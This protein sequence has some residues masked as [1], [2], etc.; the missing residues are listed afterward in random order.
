MKR[1]WSDQR[2][3]VTGASGFLGS[4]LL[5]VLERRK[6]ECIIAPRSSEYDLRDPDAI[7]RLLCR[8][9]PNLIIHLAAVCGGIGANQASPGQFFYDNAVMGI[10]LM[11]AARQH[12]VQ[13]F[14]QVGTVCA[15]PKFTPTPFK[16]DD[17]WDGYPEETNAPYGLAKKMLLVQAQAYR[18]QYGFNAIYLLPANLYGPRDH[19]DLEKSHVIPAL[20]RKILEAKEQNLPT[21]EAWGTGKPTR[22]FL[23]ARDAAEGILLAAERYDQ[24]EPVNLG[25]GQEISIRELVTLTAKLVGYKGKIIWN[26]SKPD[27]Q[28][29]RRLD[30]QRASRTFG[31]KSKVSLKIGLQKTIEWYLSTRSK[32]EGMVRP[33][34]PADQTKDP[35]EIYKH[36]GTGEILAIVVRGGFKGKTHN[37]FTPN[38]FTLQVGLNFY[39]SG[40]SIQPHIHLEQTKRIDRM[41]EVLFIKKGHVRMSLFDSKKTLVRTIDLFGGDLLLQAAGGHGFEILRSAEILEIKQGPFAGDQ[42]KVRFTSSPISPCQ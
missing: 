36:P 27:G 28:P 6:P 33:P 11:E 22:E 31:F 38:D 30:I 5:E 18:Q 7:E 34:E 42:D 40:H 16:E 2:V 12:G 23:Y 26:R 15:Y 21:V 29:K 10:H 19:F 14:V 39:P 9:R 32:A 37:F 3:L 20:I 8:H 41:Q 13:K 35:R 4:F 17:L 25:T 1:F 24:G